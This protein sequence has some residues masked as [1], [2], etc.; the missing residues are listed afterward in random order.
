MLLR[1][2]QDCER[3]AMK[4]AAAVVYVMPSTCSSI[5]H[6]IRSRSG[7]AGGGLLYHTRSIAVRM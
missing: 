1:L 4:Y 2:I 6:I 5:I 7:V 3:I